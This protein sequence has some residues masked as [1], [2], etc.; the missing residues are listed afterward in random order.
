MFAKRLI[1]LDDFIETYCKI[2]QRGYSFIFSKFTWKEIER[3]KSAFDTKREKISNWWD[4]PA[5]KQRWNLMVSGEK[6]KN[7]KSY[8][9]ER[10]FADKSNLKVLSLGSGSCHHEIE[11]AQYAVFEDILCVDI[12]EN[13]LKSA[14][15]N[16]RDN[17]LNNMRFKCENVYDYDFPNNYFDIVMFNASLHHFKNIESLLKDKVK[18][19][20]KPNGKLIINEYVGPNRL[21]FP[22]KQIDTIN[23]ALKKIDK[24]YRKRSSTRIYKN[25]YFGSGLVRMY[26]ADPS[27]CIES[28]MIL[29]SIHK[30]FKVIEEKGIGGNILMGVFKDIAYNFLDLNHEKKELIQK[31]FNIED[32]YLKQYPSDYIVGI[33]EKEGE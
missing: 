29:P 16:A 33:Y 22:Q 27:E 11:L 30:N 12:S 26:I 13:A 19:T 5:V 8:F 31:I 20:L 21:Q 18:P 28:E 7:Y 32:D 6:S 15:K 14:E 23:F 4:I 25:K 10:Y 1:T 17:N 9:V 2:K 3:T 24:K